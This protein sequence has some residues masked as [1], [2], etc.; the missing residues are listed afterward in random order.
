MFWSA[1]AL[2]LGDLDEKSFLLHH[3]VVSLSS[4]FCPHASLWTRSVMRVKGDGK[5]CTL[6]HYIN[7]DHSWKDAAQ[8][9]PN[10]NDINLAR[11]AALDIFVSEF[12]ASVNFTRGWQGLHLPS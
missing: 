7:L 12:I 5:V 4:V 2:V 6:H 9:V 11:C 1:V 10:L 3:R 8:D